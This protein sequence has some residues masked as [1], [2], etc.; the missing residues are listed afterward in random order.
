MGTI[1]RR[2]MLAGVA[3]SASVLMRRAQAAEFNLKYGNDLPA[4]HPINKRAAEACDAIRAATNG[5]VDIQIFPNSAL[6]GSTDM[7]SQVRSGALDFFTVGS[8]LA[9]LIPVSA[10]PSLAFAFPNFDGVWA[11]V[12]GDL[13][14][15]IRQQ[16][17]TIGLVG[18]DKMWDN[19]FRQITTST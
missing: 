10:I 18:F 1:S 17:A 15:H 14:A 16:I 7:L 13:G 9:N 2:A 12:D 8:P 4:G 19:G 11:A 5:R 3:V 6:G